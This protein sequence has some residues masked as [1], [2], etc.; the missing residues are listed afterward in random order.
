L[1]NQNRPEQ[2]ETKGINPPGRITLSSVWSINVQLGLEKL[3]F[4]LPRSDFLRQEEA[5]YQLGVGAE[6]EPLWTETPPTTLIKAVLNSIPEFYLRGLSGIASTS[7]GQNPN[8]NL[9][10]YPDVEPLFEGK[11][12][13]ILLLLMIEG[14]W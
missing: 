12:P 5:K 8:I 7:E 4:N 1:P 10:V 2:K 14:E 3:T 13:Q 11:S 6:G 9:V